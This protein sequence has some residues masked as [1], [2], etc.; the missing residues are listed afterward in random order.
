MAK[1]TSGIYLLRNVDPVPME[2]TMI[3]MMPF[4]VLPVQMHKP[5]PRKEAVVLT[6]AEEVLTFFKVVYI[7]VFFQLFEFL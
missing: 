3:L 2:P 7:Y 5:P 4:L 6:S 1:E